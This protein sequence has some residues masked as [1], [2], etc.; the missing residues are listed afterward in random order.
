MNQSVT[1]SLPA[2]DD[3]AR[4]DVPYHLGQFDQPYRS[5]MALARFVQSIV[6]GLSGNALDVGCGAGANIH[7][8]SR[9]FPGCQWTGVDIAGDILFPASADYFRDYDPPV[10]LLTG[11]FFKLDQILE[12]KSYD[13]VFSLQTLLVLPDYER[14]LEQLL[15]ATSGWLFITSLFSDFNVDA[16]VEVMDYTWPSHCQGPY[17]YNAYGLKR[18][19]DFC[20]ERGAKEIHVQEFEID[21]DLP[22][23]E[24]LNF[25]T[26]TRRLEDGKRLQ[27][28][29]PVYL[30]WKFIAIRMS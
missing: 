21:I 15:T 28:T 8:L 2:W 24:A 18:F 22:K 3:A 26:F 12:G 20:R 16:R 7:Y 23:P 1:P 11:D 14:A 17:Y 4:Q 5:T 6:P 19:S 10:R 13:A 30:P 25:K 27:F 29:G 9:Q